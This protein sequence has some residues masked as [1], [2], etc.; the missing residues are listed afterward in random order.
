[1]PDLPETSPRRFQKLHGCCVLIAIKERSRCKT[2]LSECLSPGARLSLTRSMLERV[3]AAASEA[4]SVRQ[5]IV[6]SPERDTVPVEFPVL[7]DTGDD[8]NA[9]LRQAHSVVRESGCHEVVVLPADLPNVRS[10]DI[11]ALVKAGRKGGFAI[12]PDASDTGTNA[13]CLVTPAPFSFRFGADSKRLHLQ[14]A[15]DTCLDANIVRLPGLA[16]DVD[17]PADLMRVNEFQW[18]I[19]LQ[20]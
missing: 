6:V 5:I 11:D 3:I 19:R 13:L 18:S 8:L 15:R 17:S 16:F 4:Q 7:A 20:A 2:R 1:M 14:E 9:A 10:A 12:A